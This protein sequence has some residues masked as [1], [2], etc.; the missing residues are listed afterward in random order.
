MRGGPPRLRRRFPLRHGHDR[1]EGGSRRSTGTDA[2]KE[3]KDPLR[4]CRCPFEESVRLLEK[5]E[6]ERIGIELRVH[7]ERRP[8]DEVEAVQNGACQGVRVDAPAMKN[9]RR[10]DEE[11]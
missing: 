8:D 7:V 4:E 10:E 5:R 9:E 6:A 1:G 3:Q 2:E 11:K